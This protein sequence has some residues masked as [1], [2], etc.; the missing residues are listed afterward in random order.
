MKKIPLTQ[1]KFALVDDD[2]YNFLMQWTW[3]ADRHPRKNFPD[4]FIAARKITVGTHKQ[5][6][7]LMHRII[8][9]AGK[10]ESIDHRNHNSLDNQKSNLRKCSQMQ[11]CQNKRMKSRILPRGVTYCK[12]EQKY[13]AQ[14]M[15]ERR[16]KFLGYYDNPQDAEKA[17]HAASIDFHKEFSIF[18]AA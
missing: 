6:T 13:L 12:R 2:D 18:K 11:N 16:N 10:D 14:I 7:I 17:Y 4:L 3:Y 8:M 1:G 5:K 9:K 15:V